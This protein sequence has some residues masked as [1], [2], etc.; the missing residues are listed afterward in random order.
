[1]SRYWDF[2]C[3][4][5]N[6]RSFLS[7]AFLEQAGMHELSPSRAPQLAFCQHLGKVLQWNARMHSIGY[8]NTTKQ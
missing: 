1:M 4:H 7:M 8:V 5:P 3:L 2:T 6:L